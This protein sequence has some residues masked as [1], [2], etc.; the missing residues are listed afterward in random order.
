MGRAAAA[1]LIELIERP[2]TALLDRVIIPGELIEGE[3]VA[4]R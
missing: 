2:K 1:K 3:S 4:Q